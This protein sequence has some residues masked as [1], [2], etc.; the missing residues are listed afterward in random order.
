MAGFGEYEFAG[1]GEISADESGEIYVYGTGTLCVEAFAN[2]L[3]DVY[4]AP[5]DH[6]RLLSFGKLECQG[7]DIRPCEGGMGMQDRNGDPFA[8]IERVNN[9]WWVR[10]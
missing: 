4:Y 5:G 8:S 3:E 9:H 6:E 1:P 7:R 10:I 2:G